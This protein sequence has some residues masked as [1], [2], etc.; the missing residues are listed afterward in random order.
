MFFLIGISLLL[1]LFLTVNLALSVASAILWRPAR[2]LLRSAEPR[3]LARSA[4]AFR[5]M[6]TIIA[7]TF[8][9]GLVMPAFLLFEPETPAETFGWRLG[10]VVALS[11]V[12]VVAACVR[13]VQSHNR[14]AELRSRWISG[15]TATTRVIENARVYALEH[16]FPVAAV[17]GVLR[18]KLFVAR[19]I[20]DTLE[21]GEIAAAL[22]HERGHIAAGDNLKRSILRVC[23]DLVIFPVGR[24]LDTDWA[25]AAELAADDFAVAEGGR[26]AA[27]DLASALLKIGKIAARTTGRINLEAAYL[28]SPEA[29]SIAS[30]V[31]RLLDIAEGNVVIRPVPQAA[32]TA[33][34]ATGAAVL[35]MVIAAT[36]AHLGLLAVVHDTSE[37]FLRVFE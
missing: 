9:F 24:Q 5:I 16:E 15:S 11:A 22:N 2:H 28:I 20:L 8:T 35:I 33:L 10:S 37:A 13:L 12:G 30:R 27:I 17:V 7:A 32:G 19:Q 31:Q 6:P 23:R 4:F 18:P 14:T 25:K 1:A 26:L 3:N 34:I 36:A 29:A 21:E